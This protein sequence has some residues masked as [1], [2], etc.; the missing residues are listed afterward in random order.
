MRDRVLVCLYVLLALLPATAMLMK[1][2]DQGVFGAVAKTTRPKLRPGSVITERYQQK[3]TQWFE[4]QLGFKGYAIHTDGTIL[5]RV[6]GEAKPD[7]S[8][9]IAGEVLFHR[10]DVNGLNRT[11]DQLPSRALVEAN[12]VRMAELQKRMRAKGRLFIPVL[13]PNKTT[14]YRDELPR[15]WTRYADAHPADAL[16][17]MMKQLLDEHG[18]EYVDSA[19]LIQAMD[20]SVAWLPTARHWSRVP[21]CEA[22]REV[23]AD[24]AKLRG[25]PPIPYDCGKVEQQERFPDFD[26][27][28]LWRLLNADMPLASRR[29]PVVRHD[30]PEPAHKPAVLL[31]GTSFCWTLIRDAAESHAFSRLYLDYYNG[32]FF[33]MPGA[34]STKVDKATPQYQEVM[35][36]ND[37][38]VL[39]VFETY[40]PLGPE[41]LDDLLQLV[42]T[43]EPR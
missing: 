6:F 35:A 43:L 26:D 21:A 41:I 31:A 9:A 1:L 16:Y 38:Y 37:I 22:M 32:T 11:P 10:E 27:F 7:S 13:I 34:A 36:P 19:P 23:L 24:Y 30:E 29:A 18:V 2:H 4:S 5:G 17:P 14:V 40:M 33:A 15:R 39:D 25:G 28:D 20:R 12:V 3:M 42:D 8:V